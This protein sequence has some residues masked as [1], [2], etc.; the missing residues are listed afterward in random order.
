MTT[1]AAL[2][3]SI[4]EAAGTIGAMDLVGAERESGA[5]GQPCSRT[6]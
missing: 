2:G 6:G 1:F 4:T 3:D 5:A